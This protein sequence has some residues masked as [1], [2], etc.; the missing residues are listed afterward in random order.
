MK[1]AVCFFL[2][3]L[4]ATV[5]CQMASK[6]ESAT[7][8]PSNRL[9]PCPQ[10][11]NCVSSLSQYPKKRIEPLGYT[12]DRSDARKRLL[13]VLSRFER[14]R[15]VVEEE[16]YIQAEFR[17]RLFGFVDITEFY[18]PADANLIHVKSASRVGYS[19][20]GVNRRRVEQIRKRFENNPDSP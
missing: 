8:D 1:I 17:S 4:Y 15:L 9:T 16:D 5:G 14:V 2:C 7:A 3:F 11:P 12:G 13:A 18:L 19:D 10:S 6:T 20:L